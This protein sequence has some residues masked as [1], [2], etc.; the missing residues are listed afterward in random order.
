MRELIDSGVSPAEAARSVAAEQAPEPAPEPVVASPS[1]D[2]ETDPYRATWMK[3][4]IHARNMDAVGI[5]REARKALTMGAAP[6]VVEKVLGP[7]MVQI[8]QD[9]H[10]GAITVAH[11][12]L[13]TEI[14]STIVQDLLRHIQPRQAA[15]TVVLGCFAHETH[16]F[17][18]YAAAFPL[19]NMGLRTLMLGARLDPEALAAAVQTL[20]PDAVGLSVTIPP[21]P[22]RLMGLLN[23]YARAVGTLPW[24]VGGAAASILEPEIKL[25][26]GL[27]ASSDHAEWTSQFGRLLGSRGRRTER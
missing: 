22:D 10:D 19:A 20:K 17:P 11:E 27:V 26:G 24:I 1:L 6:L 5:E 21:P 12:H 7:A 14:L 15:G 8:G 2:M 4:V 25:R 9:W 16:A 3:I 23:D 13:A 18:I